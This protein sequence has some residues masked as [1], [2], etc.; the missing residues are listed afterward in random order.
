MVLASFSSCDLISFFLPSFLDERAPWA[1]DSRFYS[2][3]GFTSPRDL[4]IHLVARG[5]YL[6]TTRMD[7]L[8]CGDQED[9]TEVPRDA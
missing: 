3:G 9:H 8:Y 7:K 2:Q 4:S 5:L 6:L 1:V